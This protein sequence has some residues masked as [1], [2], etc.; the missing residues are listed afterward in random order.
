MCVCVHAPS[1]SISLLISYVPL[2]STRFEHKKYLWNLNARCCL[3]CLNA[4]SSQ[5]SPSLQTVPF[6]LCYCSLSLLLIT[7]YH[8][9]FMFVLAS[10]H[11]LTLSPFIPFCPLS[12][13]FFITL[14]LSSLVTFD[15]YQV[16]IHWTSLF[17][18]YPSF[19]L[20]CKQNLQGS[21]LTPSL[22]SCPS[23]SSP[24]PFRT[25]DKKSTPWR[26]TKGTPVLVP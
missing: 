15:C 24:S 8:R 16:K 19:T 14:H 25:F 17:H 3:A 23:P 20:L 21:S 11:S 2:F 1:L 13:L 22:L 6:T 26:T 10:S 18:V 9:L 5:C 7:L 4:Y 12:L